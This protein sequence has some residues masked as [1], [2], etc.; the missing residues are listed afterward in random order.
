MTFI[1]FT[2]S[3]NLIAS[4]PGCLPF[5]SFNF[6]W[7]WSCSDVQLCIYLMEVIKK[8]SLVFFSDLKGN[9]FPLFSIRYIINCWLTIN[10]FV[11]LM[12]IPH[13]PD[14]FS[15]VTKMRCH[16]YSV[17]S[18]CNSDGLACSFLSFILLVHTAYQC[19]NKLKLY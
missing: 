1:L 2:N 6:L 19:V 12:C 15:I 17:L 11:M 4:F 14:L 7:N 3:D 13:M 5:V 10:T 16:L 9:N 8:S 18:C